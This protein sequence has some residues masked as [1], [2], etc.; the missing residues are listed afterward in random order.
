PRR[1]AGL[2]RIPLSPAQERLW[3][4]WRLDPDS[5]AYTIAGSIRLEG[6]LDVAALRS[7]AAAVVARHESLRTRFAETDGVAHQ[8]VAETPDFGWTL[9]D[10]QGLV[11]AARED[12]LER[13]LA[14]GAAMP[15][16]LVNGPLLRLRLIQLGE[17]E[18]VLQV[19]MHHIVSDAWSMPILMKEFAAFYNGARKGEAIELAPLAI[20]YGDY[21]LWQRT[22]L[23]EDAV[24][25]QLAYWRARL[26]QQHPVL[27]LPVDRPRKGGRDT[28]G[29]LVEL[30]VPADLAESLRRLS[31]AHG[32]TLFMTLLSAFQLLLY[33]YS[34]QSD[35]RIGVPVA[36]RNRLETQ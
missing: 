33:R 9:E 17:H 1:P 11:A 19:A 7:A 35:I 3:F 34:G 13:M 36:G 10:L 8:L 25:G 4:L 32:A 26:G 29:G 6:E 14:A 31:Q 22:W 2:D 24:A 28:S 16:D 20:Q 12:A 21:A 15:F 30:A 23:D 18:H 5:A 27:Q